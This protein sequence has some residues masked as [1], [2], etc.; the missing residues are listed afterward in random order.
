MYTDIR[1][2]Y[3]FGP[4]VEPYAEPTYDKVLLAGVSIDGW[5]TDDSAEEGI[6]IANILLTRNG[7]IITDWHDNGARMMRNV[8]D[9]IEEAKSKLRSVWDDYRAKNFSK[10]YFLKDRFGDLDLIRVNNWD[11]AFVERLNEAFVEWQKTQSEDHGDVYDY[12]RKFGYEIDSL[13][14]EVM[15]L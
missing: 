4:A 10:L 2:D 6:T 7:D 11:D 5:K 9:A 3:I 1:N 8:L 13:D 14:C 15:E 12:L